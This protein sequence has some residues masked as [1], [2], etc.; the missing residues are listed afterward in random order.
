[1]CILCEASAS[2]KVEALYEK[3]GYLTGKVF[4]IEADSTHVIAAGAF[5]LFQRVGCDDC[6]VGARTDTLGE[7]SLLLGSGKYR[8]FCDNINLT[9]T[10]NLIAPSQPRE[11]T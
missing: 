8:V 11:V 5:L 1:M 6:L 10:E 3:V 2:Q 9:N 7:Y 4:F